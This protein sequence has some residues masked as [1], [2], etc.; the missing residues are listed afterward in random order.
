[1]KAG[2]VPS[3]SPASARRVKLVIRLELLALLLIPLLA[4]LMARGFG[5]IPL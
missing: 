1:L 5:V 3:I 4:A 2:K